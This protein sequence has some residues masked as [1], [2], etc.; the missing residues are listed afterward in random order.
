MAAVNLGGAGSTSSAKAIAGDERD[1]YLHGSNIIGAYSLLAGFGGHN[2]LE[3]GDGIGVADY[4]AA[5]LS[6]VALLID[7]VFVASLLANDQGE[8]TIN[9]PFG[10]VDTLINIKGIAGTHGSDD[11]TGS[12]KDEYFW[13][14]GGNDRIDGGD[15]VDWVSYSDDP[16]GVFVNL[17]P[18]LG[19]DGWN[20]L[21]GEYYSGGNDSLFNIENVEGS[22][23]DDELDGDYGDNELKGLSGDDILDGNRGVDTAIYRGLRSYYIITKLENGSYTVQDRVSGRDG[24]DTVS[25]VEFLKFSDK[26]YDITDLGPNRPQAHTD[27]NGDYRSD[28]LLQN[29]SG[30]CYVWQM[31][32]GAD[33][34]TIKTGGFIGGYDGPGAKW[35]LKATGDF[36]GDGK[37]DLLLQYAD[38]GAVYVW[39]M[40]GATINK[41]GF[42]GGFDG[43]GAKWQVKATGDFNGDGKSD[44][45]MQYADTGAVYVWDMGDGA[46]GLTI[47]KGGFVGGYDGP[48][49]KWQVKGTGDFNGDGKSDILMQ[50]ADTGACYVWEMGDGAD[51]LTIKAGGFVGGYGGP[52]ADWHAT[53]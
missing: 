37:S 24:T 17:G 5:P 30:A 1:D 41:G 22:G 43:P 47:K 8:V 44:I 42:V 14:N 48:G 32:D 9:N 35:Q 11:L 3:G 23:F 51:G 12:A 36:D 31:G 28:I 25:N 10:G 38:T 46:D 4:S 50:Y 7:G 39:Q 15:G 52:G 49:A 29:T 27:L 45:L 6:L 33:G 34:L 21:D 19:R 13:G 26:T 18:H 16:S 40:N 53:V 2:T 20:M